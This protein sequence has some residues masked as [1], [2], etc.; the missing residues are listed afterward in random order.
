MNGTYKK[1]PRDSVLRTSDIK[2][3]FQEH[4]LTPKKWMGQNLLINRS[5]LNRIVEAAHVGPGEPIVEVGAGLGVLTEGL[6]DCGALVWALELDSGFFRLLQ[7]KFAGVPAVELIHADALKYDFR[8][9]AATL[10]KLRVVA[11][12]PYNISSRLVFRFLD[13]RDI[14]HSLCILLQKEVAE[15]LVAEPGT[16]DYGALTAL[17]GVFG[18][19][20]LLFNIPGK[21][22]FP[23]PDVTSTLIRI[24]FPDVPP[25]S[26]S[27]GKLLIRLVK[28]SFAGR[29]KT[30]RNT[31]K[32]GVQPDV[33]PDLVTQAANEAQIDLSRRAETLT[34]QEFGR[35]ADAIHIGLG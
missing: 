27:D 9:L 8:A 18:E 35:F 5:Y 32:K 33:S 4:G 3:I 23:V 16:K 21:A 17:L 13:N 29:R 22:F 19:A 28:T 20:R 10:G 26:V 1:T 15:R 31:L 24:S 34:P 2:R 6:L 12:L 7:E 30:L 11:N 25:V 14:F